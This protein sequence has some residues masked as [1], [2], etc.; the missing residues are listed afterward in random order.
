VYTQ[1]ISVTFLGVLQHFSKLLLADFAGQRHILK[2]QAAYNTLEAS[3]ALSLTW[4]TFL[5]S[6]P[7]FPKFL[8]FF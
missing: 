6:S 4:V 8:K 7:S 3:Q 5:L 2:D 1:K